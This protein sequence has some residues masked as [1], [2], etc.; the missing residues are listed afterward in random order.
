MTE[1]IVSALLAAVLLGIVCGLLGTFVVVRRMAL[2]GDMLS[3]AVL[4]GIVLGLAWNPDRN[5]L[6]VLACAVAA[7]VIGSVS[8]SA[9]LANTKLKADAA[10]ALVLSIYFAIGIALISRLQPAGVQAFLYGQV[11]AIDRNDLLLLS[12]VS[13]V[14]VIA[15]PFAFRVIGIVSFDPAFSRLL[16][17]PVR[18][19]ETGF[20]LLLTIVIVIAM[21]AVGVVLVTAMLVTPAA[22]ARF[23]TSSLPKTAA[24]AC[25]F[26]STGGALGVIISSGKSALPTGPVMALSVTGVFI[27][28]ALFGKR[29]GWLPTQLRRRRERVRILSEDI[30]KKLWQREE[31]AGKPVSLAQAECKQSFPGNVA[32]A[33]RLLNQAA[34]ITTGDFKISLTSEGRKRAASL[35]RSHRLWERYLTELAAYKSDHVHDSAERAEHWLDEESRRLIEERLG[36]PEID[37]HGSRIPAEVE[38]EAPP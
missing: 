30:L 29:S 12:G 24:L 14:T 5:P 25:L 27:A 21:Q 11:A 2:T 35:V 9:I 22:A 23:C 37:P 33:F 17:L 18:S 31:T 26:G 20:F 34:W 13:L 7:G 6:I 3:H 1:A 32:A 19:I 8:M 16:G 38:K 15:I 36:N 4:P 10:L 28:A